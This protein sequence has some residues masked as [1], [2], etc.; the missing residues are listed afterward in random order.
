MASFQSNQDHE[1]R[2]AINLSGSSSGYSD[3]DESEPHYPLIDRPEE[4]CSCIKEGYQKHGEF[5]TSLAAFGLRGISV[6]SLLS[7]LGS[8]SEDRFSTGKLILNGSSALALAVELARP[9]GSPAVRNKQGFGILFA[10][11]AFL[12]SL[13]LEK[14]DS[15]DAEL[16][17]W[18]FEF[19]FL[20]LLTVAD[21]LMCC[22]RRTVY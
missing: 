6:A 22:S 8:T 19:I 2:V 15:S 12:V 14:F 11:L 16:V 10:L 18:T 5:L 9:T 1:E 7:M 17:I 4:D 21:S 20:F 3:S 13:K